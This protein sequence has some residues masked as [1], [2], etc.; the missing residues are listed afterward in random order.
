MQTREKIHR[1]R[2]DITGASLPIN[3]LLMLVK[4]LRV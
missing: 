1:A 2:G 3:Q 4:V